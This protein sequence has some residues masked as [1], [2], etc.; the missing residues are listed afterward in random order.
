MTP[1]QYMI[2]VLRSAAPHHLDLTD[3]TI[4]LGLRGETGEVADVVKKAIGHRQGWAP[5]VDGMGKRVDPRANM[6]KELGDCSWYG[7]AHIHRLSIAPEIMIMT[8]IEFTDGLEDLADLLCEAGSRL[9]HA[10]F[11]WEGADAGIEFFALIQAIGQR[12]TPPV[13]ISEI[14]E[15][16]VSKLRVRY[17]EGFNVAASMAKVDEAPA[18]KDRPFFVVDVPP[19]TLTPEVI[20]RLK[21]SK[22]GPIVDLT[23]EPVPCDGGGCGHPCN[24][25]QAAYGSRCDGSESRELRC[26]GSVRACVC[27]KP[28]AR[29][30][31][32]G[33][34]VGEFAEGSGPALLAQA[35]KALARHGCLGATEVDDFATAGNGYPVKES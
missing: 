5:Y 10:T 16:N 31:S 33:K 14:W 34:V 19:G 9:G 26:A 21:N 2:E 22:P 1:A 17:P 25:C 35:G 18:E 6:I 30:E 13:S 8:R 3:K 32:I 28:K 11:G 4:L 20:E 24:K 23:V 12:M 15:T 7:A 27:N 29:P